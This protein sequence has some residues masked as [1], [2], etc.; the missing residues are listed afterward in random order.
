MTRYVVH[1]SQAPQLPHQIGDPFES[2][3]Q[4]EAAARKAGAIGDGEP[5][6]HDLV[7]DLD[8]H[9]GE[10]DCG[11]WIEVSQATKSMFGINR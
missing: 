11:I 1:Y 2:L 7:Y 4:A 3:A 5:S 9:E 8:G 10:N 6:G